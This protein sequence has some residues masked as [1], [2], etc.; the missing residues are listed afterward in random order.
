MRDEQVPK[1]V[2][3]YMPSDVYEWYGYA[4]WKFVSGL[5]MKVFRIPS[6]IF[7]DVRDQNVTLDSKMQQ[8]LNVELT[9]KYA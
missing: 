9:K 5:E 1:P 7:K 3:I 2:M 8:A 6:N 4:A